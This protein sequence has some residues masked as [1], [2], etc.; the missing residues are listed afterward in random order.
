MPIVTNINLEYKLNAISID[1]V[2]YSMELK[3]DRG[4]VENDQFTCLNTFDLSVCQADTVA[5]MHS[6]PVG[7]TI[8]D[9]LKASI[10]QYLLDK[11]IVTGTIS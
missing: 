2:N 3:V 1:T 8:Y 10:Y 7:S 11:N 4:I 9:V 5:L 6:A